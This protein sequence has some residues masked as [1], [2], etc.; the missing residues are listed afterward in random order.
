[1]LMGRGIECVRDGLSLGP[2][3]HVT[4]NCLFS[5]SPHASRSF[6]MPACH[7]PAIPATL[8]GYLKGHRRVLSAR[9]T[10]PSR[11]SSSWQNMT[12]RSV[13]EST[14]QLRSAYLTPRR[15]NHPSPAVRLRSAMSVPAAQ[16]GT[17]TTVPAEPLVP[18]GNS[19]IPAGQPVPGTSDA[20]QPGAGR[21][22][23]GRGDGQP[24][25]G[26]LPATPARGVPLPGGHTPT[27]DMAYYAQRLK[28]LEDKMERSHR[29]R[30]RSTRSRSSRPDSGRRGLKSSRRSP[31]RRSAHRPSQPRSRAPSSSSTRRP[32]TR[33]RSGSHRRRRS[34]SRTRHRHSRSSSRRRS[35]SRSRRHQSRSRA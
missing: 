10:G 28:T 5:H 6:H 20:G 34:R 18:A 13:R 2:L 12:H 30:S 22:V 29:S 31:R 32:H 35:R 3:G 24:I 7:G 26:Q 1:M 25:P 11:S 4:M 14:K 17:A 15:K 9:C 33:S 21:Q 23:P 8:Q 27:N 16:P 19:Q